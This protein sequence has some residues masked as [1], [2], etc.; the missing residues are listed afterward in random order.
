MYSAAQDTP[1][2]TFYDGATAGV[3]VRFVTSGSKLEVRRGTTQLAITGTLTITTG[4]WHYLELKVKCHATEGTYEV[5]LDGVSQLSG[6][7]V[8]TQEGSARL[9]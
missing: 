4:E 8:N 1:F 2:L 7:E 9:P 3:N 5:R 6:T